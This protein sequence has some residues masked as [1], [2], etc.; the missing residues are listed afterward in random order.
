MTRPCLQVWLA[1]AALSGNRNLR[2]HITR[3]PVATTEPPLSRLSQGNLLARLWNIGDPVKA[4]TQGLL[5][6]LQR[7]LDSIGGRGGGHADLPVGL[8]LRGGDEALWLGQ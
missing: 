7:R 4:F 6:D 3:Q 1:A 5:Q 2:L 8:G